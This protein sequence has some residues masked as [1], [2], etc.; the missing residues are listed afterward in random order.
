ME[1][2]RAKVLLVDEIGSVK[3]YLLIYLRKIGCLCSLARSNDEACDLFRWDEF[4]LILSRFSPL[5]GSCHELVMLSA[6]TRSSFFH[7]YHFENG[8]W[9]IPRVRFGQECWGETALHPRQFAHVLKR[10]I[11]DITCRVFAGDGASEKTGKPSLQAPAR[12]LLRVQDWQNVTADQAVLA[13]GP[14]TS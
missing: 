6:G 11:Q 12:R 13:Y 3:N 4:D 7:F 9:W 8:C 10:L 2:A 14:K 5:G 1:P